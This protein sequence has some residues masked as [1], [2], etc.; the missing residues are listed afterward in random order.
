MGWRRIVNSLRRRRLDED[1]DRELEFHLDMRAAAFEREGLS[2]D[3]ARRKAQRLLGNPASLRDRTREVD[4]SVSLETALQDVRY[5]LRTLWRAPLFTLA[6]A[7]TL[8]LGIGVNTAMFGVLYGV[9]IRPLPYADPDRLYVLHQGGPH[10]RTRAAPLDFADWQQRSRAF[11]MAAVIGTGFTLT[12]DGEPELVVGELVAGDLFGLL[13]VQPLAGRTFAPDERDRGDAQ[14]VVLSHALWQRRFGGDPG[15]VGRR[16]TA[17]GRPYTVIGVMPP[18]FGVRGDRYELWTPFPFRGTN[19]DN[20]PVTRTSRYMHVVARLKDGVTPAAASQD[21]GAIAG[22]LAD[23][24]PESHRDSRILMSSLANETVGDV[25]LALQLLFAAVMLVLLIACGNVM[26]LL[27]ARFSVRGTEIQVRAALGA[28]RGRLIRQFFTETLVL[29]GLGTSAGLLLAFWLLRLLPAFAA[30]AVPRIGEIALVPP[31]I[32]FTCGV[33]L[34]AA[35]LFGLAPAW[36]ATRAAGAARATVRTFTTGRTQQRFRSG[37]VVGQVAVALCLMTSA[38]LIGRSLMTLQAVEKGF[39]TDGRITFNLVMPAA[40][41]PTPAAMHAFYR[42]VLESLAAQAALESVGATTHLPL[43]GQD[44]ENAF[45]V[46]GY[47]PSSADPQPVAA[48]RG[49]SAGYTAVMGIPLRA[50]RGLT[51][52]DDERGARVAVVNDAFARRYW[53]G[54]DPVGRRVAVGIA[55]GDWHTVVGVIGDVKHRGPA[56]EARPEVLVPYLQLDPGFLTA[57]AR[58]FS[59]VARSDMAS[60]AVIRSIRQ[61][62]GEVDP[63][64][65]V[66]TPQPMDALVAEAVAAPRF[67]AYLLATFAVVAAALAAIG[68]FG[69]LS[70]LVS[71][72]TREIGIRLALGAQHAAIFRDVLGQ[73]AKLVALGTVLGLAG[74]ALLARWIAALLF[75]VSPADPLALGAAVGALALVA[76]TAAF[77]PAC[78]ATRVDP[79]VALRAP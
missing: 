12:G 27:L 21:L 72:R 47:A 28:S 76:L 63:L 13:S 22:A 37:V 9:L 52:G 74:G 36:R 19:P 33:S 61:A 73:G 1:I 45:T 78:S 18:R 46:E 77:I 58:G 26:S 29:Y 44:L 49:V 25:R 51:A 3:A 2:P 15:V 60:S 64:V 43:S 70:Y 48:L 42:R 4:V 31:V 53:P 7:L 38:S 55:G 30:G 14:V 68:V 59:V 32:L 50:G 10:G 20:L 8:A 75:G 34:A 24:Y 62:V 57:W 17:N 67:R 16:M 71:D 40:R 11:E 6:A 69:V 35:F 56:G 39:D 41:F 23:E 79:L 5:A 54:L 65:P 66:I